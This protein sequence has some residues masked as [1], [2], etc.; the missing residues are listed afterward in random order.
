MY[1]E[2]LTRRGERVEAWETLPSAI[3]T[4]RRSKRLR[5][6]TLVK[7]DSSTIVFGNKIERWW[8]SS[9]KSFNCRLSSLAFHNIGYKTVQTLIYKPAWAYSDRVTRSSKEFSLC[10]ALLNFH[11][12]DFTK[13]ISEIYE[14]LCFLAGLINTSTWSAVL[15]TLRRQASRRC[16]RHPQE[17]NWSLAITCHRWQRHRSLICRINDMS[18]HKLVIICTGKKILGK[19]NKLLSRIGCLLREE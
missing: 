19:N 14:S 5:F 18:H 6:L 3:P 12:F 4:C 7:T 16:H 15:F 10:P 1:I 17:N 11:Q 13:K 9:R 2:Q 8:W